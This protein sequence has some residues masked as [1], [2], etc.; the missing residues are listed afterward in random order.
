MQDAE[1]LSFGDWRYLRSIGKL[2]HAE[3]TTYLT[4]EPRL[5]ALLNYFIERPN[6]I[7]SR[8]TLLLDV[9]GEGVGSDEALTRAV[10]ALRK[11]LRDTRTAPSFIATRSKKG[12]CWLAQVSVVSESD[13][14]PVESDEGDSDE[15]TY[16]EQQLLQNWQQRRLFRLKRLRQIWFM[17]ILLFVSSLLFIIFFNQMNH[18]A[19]LPRYLQILPISS[20]D[21]D[22]TQPL[23]TEDQ[24]FML[25]AHQRVQTQGWHWAL[26]QLQSMQ[27]NHDSV[28]YQQLSNA[29]WLSPSLILFRAKT[30]EGC[31]FWSQHMLP[32]LQEAKKLFTCQSFLARGHVLS[33]SKILWLEKDKSTGQA[34]LWQW[35]RETESQELLL[36]F[37]MSWRGVD[38]LLYRKGKAYVLAQL[39]YRHSNLVEINLQSLSW[40][41]L[42]SYNF[43]ADQLAFW[44][45]RELLLN[46]DEE[47][48][49]VLSLRSGNT[50]VFGEQSTNLR[51]VSRVND[52]LLA[53]TPKR[54]P[55]DLV[56]IE[57]LPEGQLHYTNFAPSNKTDSLFLHTSEGDFFVSDR[58][59]VPQVW[60][61]R[62]GRLQ[63]V[64]RFSQKLRL[65]QLLWWQ[66][67]LW[68]VSEHSLSRLSLDGHLQEPL[69][70]RSQSER[71]AVCSGQLY[72]TEFIG[73][74]WSLFRWK[75]HHAE[76][77]QTNVVNVV[78]GQAGTLLVQLANS[79]QLHQWNEGQLSALPVQLDW[80]EMEASHITQDKQAVYWLGAQQLTLHRYDL[81]SAKLSQ[82]ALPYRA[83]AIYA[84]KGTLY[85]E[86]AR[87]TDRDVVW[88]HPEQQNR[89]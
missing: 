53:V 64:S 10:A 15:V 58:T 84:A 25:Y 89:S 67:G 79:A 42:K 77:V 31:A 26:Q 2:Q 5:H 80:R 54:G 19:S 66:G 83:Q 34:Q 7:I 63:Q 43:R 30:N 59:G 45:E 41:P 72:W 12:Y 65:E 20:Q 22:E 37:P 17:S 38:H 36:S 11:V 52:S 40:K 61:Q 56:H 49:E 23:V 6:E 44:D 4:L 18:K 28:E 70:T 81:Q 73:N 62:E 87:E 13:A 24:A 75:E 55:T 8:E 51:D 47:R 48:L 82:W 71:F 85:L 9:W 14:K 27:V 29:I 78:C 88:L 21:G 33:G 74:S 60:V 3:E 1:Q 50:R 57:L 69:F 46:H 68:V 76:P 32:H 35:D 86:Q 39:G 16:V